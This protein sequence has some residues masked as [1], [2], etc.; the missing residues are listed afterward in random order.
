[1]TTKKSANNITKCIEILVE[2]EGIVKLKERV[3]LIALYYVN[4]HSRV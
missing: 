3:T 2:F 4:N 1:M